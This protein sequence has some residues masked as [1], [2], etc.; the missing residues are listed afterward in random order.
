MQIKADRL[1]LFGGEE[2][3]RI[4]TPPK[5]AKVKFIWNES[6]R[7]WKAFYGIDG[8]D[9]NTEFPQ[10]K[11]GIYYEKPWS[12]STTAFIQMSNGSVDVDHYEVKPI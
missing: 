2:E 9:A 8:D 10:S 4:S 3:L 7:Q 6:A 1:E 11:D 5:S 12:D